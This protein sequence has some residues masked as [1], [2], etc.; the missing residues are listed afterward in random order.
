MAA[1]TRCAVSGNSLNRTLRWREMDSNLRFR[2]RSVPISG[3]PVRLPS[4][5]TASRPGTGVRIQQRV[6]SEPAS[7]CTFAPMASYRLPQRGIRITGGS[8]QAAARHDSAEPRR[9]NASPITF[10]KAPRWWHC[11]FARASPCG[12]ESLL[13]GSARWRAAPGVVDLE[14]AASDDA[15]LVDVGSRDDNTWRVESQTEVS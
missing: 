14:L 15:T 10:R 13:F 12:E 6:R 4:R 11:L 8:P 3:Q 9:Y 1:L 2:N 5:L 7:L